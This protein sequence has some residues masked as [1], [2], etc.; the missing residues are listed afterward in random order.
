MITCEI[1]VFIKKDTIVEY[2]FLRTAS[3]SE[4]TGD[5]SHPLSP[6]EE[7]EVTTA[8][9]NEEHGTGVSSYNQSAGNIT[10]GCFMAHQK[11]S[12]LHNF[13]VPGCAHLY[14]LIRQSI[15]GIFYCNLL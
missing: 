12:M 4:G 13:V 10:I 3:G 7:T 14:F 11:L 9:T 6:I 2:L 15:S 5:V 8:D 1:A